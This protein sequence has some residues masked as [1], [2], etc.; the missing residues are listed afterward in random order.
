MA[1]RRVFF[2]GDYF[3]KFYGRLN[4]KTKVKFDYV[5]N[6]VA[7]VEMAPEKFLKH[8]EGTQGLYEIR[9]EA[10]R[11][12]YRIFCFF[13][14]ARSIILLNAFEKKTEKTPRNE[15]ALAERLRR[16]YF[17]EKSKA[18]SCHEQ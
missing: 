18:E 2:F 15:I 1:I 6:L 13:E 3:E 7:C 17:L 10:R 5:L 4:K 12:A 11:N 14:E 8:L 16:R 9:V